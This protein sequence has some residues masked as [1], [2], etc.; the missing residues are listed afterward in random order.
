[1]KSNNGNKDGRRLWEALGNIKEEYVEEAAPDLKAIA[2]RRRIKSGMIATFAACVAVSFCACIPLMNTFNEPKGEDFAEGKNS[3]AT[4]DGEDVNDAPTD[5]GAPDTMPETSN[6]DDAAAGEGE[7]EGEGE[8]KPSEGSNI[9]PPYPEGV[10]IVQVHCSE[11]DIRQTKIYPLDGAKIELELWLLD[12]LMGEGDLVVEVETDA[13][14]V[15]EGKIITIEDFTYDHYTQATPKKLTFTLKPIILGEGYGEIA[16]KYCFKPDL[17]NSMYAI[18]YEY[19][20]ALGGTWPYWPC[21]TLTEYAYVVNEFE[22]AIAQGG[23]PR[24]MYWERLAA[25]YDRGAIT[26]EEYARKY[27]EDFYKND[28]FAA[29]D[30][31]YADGSFEFSYGSK[32]IRYESGKLN[33]KTLLSAFESCQGGNT[34]AFAVAAV[35]YLYANGIITKTEYDREIAWLQSGVD[36]STSSPGF[37]PAVQA[38]AAILQKYMLTH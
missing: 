30:V 33:D 17:D 12:C 8:G 6:D 18:I 5:T 22:V 36:V 34:Y 9:I 14:T 24:D 35:E 20:E 28:V 11:M 23:S 2:R 15:A 1:M 3:E 29:I 10:P 21:V 25:A 27:F 19:F 7:G 16:I 31:Q 32:Y 38:H 13:F 26:G 37:Y 4:L